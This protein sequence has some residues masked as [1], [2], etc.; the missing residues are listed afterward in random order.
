MKIVKE[1]DAGPILL[2]QAAE[3]NEH[4][5]APEH[6]MVIADE[7]TDAAGVRGWVGDHRVG[8]RS[9]VEK[10]PTLDH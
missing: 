5:A 4:E 10:P 3:I 1:L 2:Q 7:D 9:R 8:S 6:R